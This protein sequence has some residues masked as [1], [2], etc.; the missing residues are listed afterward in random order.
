MGSMLKYIEDEPELRDRFVEQAWTQ[1]SQIENIE[2]FEKALRKAFDTEKGR[3]ASRFFS[4]AE[5]KALWTSAENRAK[6]KNAIGEGRTEFLM[7][8]PMEDSVPINKISVERTD[9]KMIVVEKKISTKGYSRHGHKIR[10]YN[11]SFIRWTPAE[12]RF[13]R[14]RKEKKVPTSQIVEEYNQHF[15]V[16]RSKSSISTKVRR[17]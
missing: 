14:V 3:N 6:L 5:I 11:R 10:A 7:S 13:I 4:D 2:D 12:A 8:Y 9:G 15:S 1:D 16:K 17:V